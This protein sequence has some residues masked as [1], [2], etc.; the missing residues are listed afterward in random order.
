MQLSEH[1]ELAEFLVSETAARRGIANEPTP[2]IVDNL[3]QL[4]QVVLEPLRR[5]LKRPVLITSG[6]RSMYR[7]GASILRTF[8]PLSY[9]AF[10][11]LSSLVSIN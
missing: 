8:S 1:F 7:P 10:F 4:C 6:F 2:E 5:Q 3:Q 11:R 9:R